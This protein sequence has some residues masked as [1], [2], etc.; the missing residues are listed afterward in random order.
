MVLCEFF[1]A[2]IKRNPFSAKQL[3]LVYLL[4]WADVRTEC[5]AGHTRGIQSSPRGFGLSKLTCVHRNLWQT[6]IFLIYPNLSSEAYFWPGWKFSW[7][8]A[9][10]YLFSIPELFSQLIIG[11]FYLFM[12]SKFLKLINTVLFLCWHKAVQW[13]LKQTFRWESWKATRTLKTGQLWHTRQFRQ[14]TCRLKT[15]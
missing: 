15:F 9:K 4:L 13:C 8:T 11:M 6:L 1:T 10:P 14:V 7:E 2:P 3:S 5:L 12:F